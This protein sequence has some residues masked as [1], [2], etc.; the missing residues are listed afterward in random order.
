MSTCKTREYIHTVQIPMYPMVEIHETYHKNFIGMAKTN[1]ATE[2]SE[3]SHALLYYLDNR[4]PDNGKVYV[5][6]YGCC[7]LSTPTEFDH[8]FVFD[9]LKDAEEIGKDRDFFKEGC[10]YCNEFFGG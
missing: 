6:A 5:D 3:C 4:N 1:M 10:M 7:S 2:D 9:S 8:T